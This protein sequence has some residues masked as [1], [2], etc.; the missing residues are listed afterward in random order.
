MNLLPALLSVVW[1]AAA[2]GKP[3]SAEETRLFDEGMRAFQAG[4]PRDADRAWRAGF[5]LSRDPAF[6]VRMGEAEEKAGLLV[7][8]AES[9]RRYLH[10]APDAADR[11][12]IEQR[13]ARLGP[14]GEPAAGASGAGAGAADPTAAFGAG[15]LTG[16]TTTSAAG[17]GL[18]AGVPAPAR[19]DELAR[20]ANG[21]EEASGW[22]PLNITAWVA[23]GATV[24]LLG[25]SGYYAAS[26]GSAK[27][28]VNLLSRYQDPLTGAPLEYHTIAARY[29]GRTRDGRHDDRVAKDALFVAAG[30]A[31]V[32]TVFFILDAV[33]ARDEHHAQRERARPTRGP[34]LG[35]G[36]GPETGRAGRP[37]AFSSLRWSF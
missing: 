27:D 33:R 26:A 9:Y 11:A 16:G 10:A 22:T 8:A 14:A 6:L 17:A 5:A 1:L 29:E 7:E 19:D 32:A 24:L 15:G 30:T 3:P 34:R 35:L 28:D 13:L 21:D 25:A 23:T 4:N 18:P 12:E 37:S 20:R 36:I 2:P 31:V